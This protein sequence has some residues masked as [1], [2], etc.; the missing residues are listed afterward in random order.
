M[1]P[2]RLWGAPI[3]WAPVNSNVSQHMKHL[4][5]A[6]FLFACGAS[7]ASGDFALLG[8]FARV[9]SADNGEHCSGYSLDLWESKASL[10]GLLHHHSGLCGDPPCAVIEQAALNRSSGRLAFTS[11]IGTERFRFVGVVRGKRVVGKLN[12]RMVRLDREPDDTGGFEPDTNVRAWCSCWES[13]P[14]CR[15]VKE[16]CAQLQ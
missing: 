5:L 10:V 8:H 13:V 14:R 15:G 9:T 3:P 4:L 6:G 11:K 12:D 2:D 1:R 16:L 7:F